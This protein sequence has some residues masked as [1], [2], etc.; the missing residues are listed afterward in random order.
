MKP[1][2]LIPITAAAC[3]LAITTGLTG[4]GRAHSRAESAAHRRALAQRDA[5]RVLDLRAVRATIAPDKRP[6]A[7]IIA[8]ISDALTAAGIPSTVLGNVGAST[9]TPG[10]TAD[11]PPTSTQSV[12]FTLEPI[13]TTQLGAFLDAWR[14][15][16][17]LWTVT[18]IEL[19]TSARPTDQ[20]ASYI[21]RLTIK[22]VYLTQESTP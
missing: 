11:G 12:R 10:R 20:A 22:A 4:L 2:L 8:R 18:Q 21:A 9:N 14:T 13:T 6:Q 3:V 7:D 16:Q 17:R 19:T 15:T 5:Q 1:R